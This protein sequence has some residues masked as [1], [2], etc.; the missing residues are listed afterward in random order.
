V[1]NQF[2]TNPGDTV[3][4]HI[5]QKRVAY[6]FYEG[7]SDFLETL[8]VYQGWNWSIYD[9]QLGHVVACGT[10]GINALSAR[11]AAETEWRAYRNAPAGLVKW[12]A[13]KSDLWEAVRM[14]KKK[15]APRGETAEM[16]QSLDS[17]EDPLKLRQRA[18]ELKAKAARFTNEADDLFSRAEQIE[19]TRKRLARR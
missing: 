8:R 4:D 6:M 11:K 10:T 7:H 19:A 3:S 5:G 14:A 13:P 16:H 9:G 18:E 1:L 17:K 15:F 12:R 2:G